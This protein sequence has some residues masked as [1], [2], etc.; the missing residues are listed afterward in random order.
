[1]VVVCFG[2]WPSKSFVVSTTIRP[3]FMERVK[4]AGKEKQEMESLKMEN[5]I[6]TRINK[7]FEFLD[8][9]SFFVF[10]PSRNS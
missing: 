5:I 2:R 9:K 6:K 3:S 4:T 7:C 1:M 8:S 10:F